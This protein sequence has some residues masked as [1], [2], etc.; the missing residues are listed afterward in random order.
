M[1]LA[2]LLFCS[3]LALGGTCYG[4]N[5][6]EWKDELERRH[7]TRVSKRMQYVASHKAV[8]P[9]YRLP[10]PIVIYAPVSY[11]VWPIFSSG[12]PWYEPYHDSYI[13]RPSWR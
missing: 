13:F 12:T 11:P 4:H 9:L 1:K 7:A 3:L 8:Y 10:G 2:T 6:K 5:A